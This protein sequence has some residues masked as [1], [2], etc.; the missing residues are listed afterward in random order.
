MSAAAIHLLQNDICIHL[1]VAIC[2]AMF[3][4]AGFVETEAAESLF[5]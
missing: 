5:T 1:G 2:V 4:A 3:V